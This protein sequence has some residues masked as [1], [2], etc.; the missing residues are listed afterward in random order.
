MA[1]TKEI[2]IP[3]SDCRECAFRW[4]SEDAEIGCDIYEDAHRDL[5]EDD[6]GGPVAKPDM[7]KATKVLVV[8]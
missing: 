8:E 6:D 1:V 2:I 4:E 3:K 5:P 7:C